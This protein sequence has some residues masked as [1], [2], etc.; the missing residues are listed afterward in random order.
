MDPAVVTQRLDGN[1][2]A[3]LVAELEAVGDRFCRAEDAH[4]HP[5]DFVG[6]NPFAQRW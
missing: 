1:V 6:F 4:R 5:I 2:G 3:D